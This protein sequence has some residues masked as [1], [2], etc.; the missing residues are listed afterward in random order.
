MNIVLLGSPGAGK[1]TQARFINEKYQ[2]PIIATGELLRSVA[3]NETPIGKAVRDALSNGDF[4]D[5]NFTIQLVKQQIAKI[6]NGNGIVFNGFPR[7]LEQAKALADIGIKI[8]AV[9]EL[10]VDDDKIAKRLRGRREHPTSGRGY[11][12]VY[13]PPKKRGTDDL[14]GEALVQRDDD[15]RG[16]V[17]HRLIEYQEHTEPVADYFASQ[18]ALSQANSHVFARIKGDDT[19]ENVRNHIFNKLDK[20]SST[21]KLQ[22]HINKLH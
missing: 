22:N 15:R 7:N 3:Q 9:V 11:H 14:T 5:D 4:V 8:D 17:C 19:M 20:V 10:C 21:G 18:A 12:L 1:S 6:K 13:N 2:L 16:T